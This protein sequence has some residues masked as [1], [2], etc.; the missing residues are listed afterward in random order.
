MILEEAGIVFFS[1][2]RSL[3]VACSSF[4]EYVLADR[5]SLVSQVHISRLEFRFDVVIPCPQ[6]RLGGVDWQ[7]MRSQLVLPSGAS[8]CAYQV[9]EHSMK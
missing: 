9:P 8:Y 2:S 5:H 4:P 7:R 6:H 1:A 3:G